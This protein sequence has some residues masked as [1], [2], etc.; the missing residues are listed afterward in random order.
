MAP[1]PESGA[2]LPPACSAPG[3]LAG[4]NS[5]IPHDEDEKHAEAGVPTQEQRNNG[6]G[7]GPFETGGPEIG[8]H[9]PPEAGA[10]MNGAQQ[11]TAEVAASGEVAALPRP[12]VSPPLDTGT[13]RPSIAAAAGRYAR[14]AGVGGGTSL[15]RGAGT[16]HHCHKDSRK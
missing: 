8:A 10:C 6:A 2:P 7:D 3:L 15:A 16:G 9:A 1:A 4:A 14:G 12:A 13:P 11:S 5:A